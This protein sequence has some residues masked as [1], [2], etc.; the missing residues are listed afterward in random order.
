MLP[1]WAKLHRM[2]PT[3]PLAE[4]VRLGQLAGPAALQQQ[5]S[6]QLMS[7]G[8]HSWQLAEQMRV[9]QLAGPID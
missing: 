4:Q 1:P 6:N 7:A 5:F 2:D 9:V 8:H 3:R